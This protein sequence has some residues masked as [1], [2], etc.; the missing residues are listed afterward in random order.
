MERLRCCT[1]TL[2]FIIL[3]LN[4]SI[5]STESASCCLSYSRRPIR[6]QK[7][8]GYTMQ[9]I[10]TS[11]D[12]KAIIFHTVGERFICADPAREWTHHRIQCLKDKAAR[13]SSSLIAKKK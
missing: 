11:C 3:I 7:L 5:L 1:L 13:M 2:L 9:D 4:T 12:I 6:C 8:K 10:T